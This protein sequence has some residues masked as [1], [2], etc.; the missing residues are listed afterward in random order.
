MNVLILT[1]VEGISCIDKIEQIDENNPAY[2]ETIELLMKD[3]NTAISASFDGGAEKVYVVDGHGS[4][5]NFNLDRV[6]SRA[7]VILPKE[8]ATFIKDIDAL[9]LVGMHAMAGNQSGFLNHTQS[10]LRIHHYRYNGDRIGEICQAGTYAGHFGIPCVA[11]TGDLEACREAEAFL[12]KDVFTAAVKTST[13]RNA[14]Q[15]L[16]LEEATDLIYNAVKSGVEN[17]KQIPPLK[18]ELPLKITVEFNRTDFCDAACRANPKVKRIDAYT[19]QSIK[20]EIVAYSDV[21]L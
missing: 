1:D 3:T 9:V 7:K 15:A 16:S 20:E 6:D 4:G 10:S 12:G 8:I 5:K 14:A 11:V 21:L 17:Y 2:P 18:S 19:A 13:E